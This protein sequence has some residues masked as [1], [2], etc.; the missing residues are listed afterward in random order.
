MARGG[1]WAVVPCKELSWAKERLSGIL[2]R[3]ERRALACAMLEDVL[4][5]L[6]SLDALAGIMVVT[7]DPVVLALAARRRLRVVAD[8]RQ[9][10]QSDAIGAAARVLADEG[11]PGMVAVPADVPLATPAELAQVIAGHERGPLVTLVP[12]LADRG[13]NA[14]AATP[15]HAVPFRFGRSSF[16]AHLAAAKERGA[17]VRSFVLPGLGLD[18]DRPADL[19]SFLAQPSATRSYALLSAGGV[20]ERLRRLDEVPPRS[21]G[22]GR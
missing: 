6:A 2:S 20:A 8:E 4:D 16:A 14:I 3:D 5:A 22:D 7:C 13:T 15:A 21:I 9:A 1:I 10:G 19:L 11:A 12:A 17:E 18:L